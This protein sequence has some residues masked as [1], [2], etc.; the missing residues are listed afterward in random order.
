MAIT[1]IYPG[2]FDPITYGH[3]DLINRAANSFAAVLVAVADN[4]GKS[5]LFS[6]AERIQLAKRVLKPLYPLVTVQGF[7]GLLTQFA[8]SQKIHLILRGL[9][10]VSDLEH[11]FQLASANR[12]VMPEL[13]T[14]FLMPAEQQAFTSAT[15][16][17]EIASLGGDV[18]PFVHS[19]VKTALKN[20]LF[21]R[22]EALTE[23][24]TNKR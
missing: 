13:E 3:F 1:V 11:E 6:H 12:R 8:Q 7:T 17:R 22:K 20:K 4:P 23:V 14:V 18:S 5:T 21:P 10:A 9:R 15:I 24:E 19:V 2:T 16:V